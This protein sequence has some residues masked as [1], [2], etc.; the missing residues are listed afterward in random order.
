MSYNNLYSVPRA[1]K[2]NN[3]LREDFLNAQWD[4]FIYYA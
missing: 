3:K 2:T 4:V 1:L